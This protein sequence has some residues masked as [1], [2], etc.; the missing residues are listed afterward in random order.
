MRPTSG[1]SRRASRCRSP[2]IPTSG[3]RSSWRGRRRRDGRPSPRQLVFE[4]AAGLVVVELVEEGGK[5]VGAELTAPEAHS[6]RDATRTEQAAACLALAA[7]DIATDRHRRRSARWGCRSSSWS[8]A[9]ATRCAG[10][11]PTCARSGHLMPLGGADAIWCYTRDVAPED[12]RRRPGA[13]VL[14][15]R[16]HGRGPGDRQR[17]RRRGRAVGRPVGPP[18]RRAPLPGQPGRRHGPA[19]PPPAAGRS[20][21]TGRSRR[22][23]SPAGRSR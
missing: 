23:T 4:E 5:V 22:S 1:S 20:S 3:R 6:R 21:A 17:H 13:D 8:C 2:V 7:D 11:R 9:L 19:E 16:R 10:R 12:E 15:A 18:R 14:A